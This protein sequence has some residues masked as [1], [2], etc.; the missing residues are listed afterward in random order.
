VFDKGGAFVKVI[1]YQG[2][3][4]G[5]FVRPKGLDIDRDGHL[6]VADA[7]FEIIQIFDVDSAEPLLPFGKYGPA[8]GSTYLPA[9]VHIDYDNVAYFS[10][11]ADPDFRVE[12]LVYVGNMLGDRKLNVYGF[13]EWVGPSLKGYARPGTAQADRQQET[14][15]SPDGV[16]GSQGAGTPDQPGADAK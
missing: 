1:G 11:Y 2:S 5:A 15:P 3:H 4:P 9:G 6:Y 7:G 10:R 14:V 8:P 12:Y 16:A 13:G